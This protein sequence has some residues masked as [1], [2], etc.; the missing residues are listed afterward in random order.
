[1]RSLFK[2]FLMF[3]PFVLLVSP[4][5]FAAGNQPARIKVIDSFYDFGH[6]PMD[7]K[8]VHHFRIKNEGA[9]D[10]NID[11][12]I[13]NCDCTT[14][15]ILNKTVPPDS[16]G[17]IK[18]VFDTREYYGSNTRNVTVYSNDIKNPTVVLKYSSDIG[19]IPREFR[20]EPQSLFFLPGHKSKDVK[21]FNSTDGDIEYDIEME[22]DSIFSIGKT[23]GKIKKGEPAIIKIT[24]RDDLPRGTHHSN[25]TVSYKS[26]TIYPVGRII[27]ISPYRTKV[28]NLRVSRYPLK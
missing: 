12:A 14:A 16:I 1:M 17:E 20:A 15:I 18:V 4:A 21:L 7:Y 27:V 23:N 10:L 19:V 22:I 5:I 25:F 8:L 6:V 11:K 3:L 26:E 2:I 28:K 13:S 24:P 9:S